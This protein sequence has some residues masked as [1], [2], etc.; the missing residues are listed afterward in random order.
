MEKIDKDVKE[1]LDNAII[2]V[3]GYAFSKC[4]IGYRIF[5]SW[6]KHAVVLSEDGVVLESSMDEIEEEIAKD[7]FKKDKKFLKDEGEEE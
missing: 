1:I 7:Y 2:V 3:N 6:T 4:D 5:S